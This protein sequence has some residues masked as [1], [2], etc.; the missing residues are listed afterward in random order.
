MA[1]CTKDNDIFG[2]LD[3]DRTSRAKR[4]VIL[5]DF[6]S[7]SAKKSIRLVLDVTDLKLT[8]IA[9]NGNY[10]YAPGSVFR[11]WK[12]KKIRLASNRLEVDWLLEN[13]D[14]KTSLKIRC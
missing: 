4:L 10:L 8:S 1:E 9:T 7:I 13:V 2:V 11:G 6:Y 3:V 5:Q 14:W 12:M